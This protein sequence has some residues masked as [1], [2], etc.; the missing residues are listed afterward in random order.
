MSV[1]RGGRRGAWPHI[2]IMG[3]WSGLAGQCEISG[4][5]ATLCSGHCY[6]PAANSVLA[7]LQWHCNC[8]APTA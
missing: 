8:G 3:E 7:A 2:D 4:G 1:R 5:G 6:S